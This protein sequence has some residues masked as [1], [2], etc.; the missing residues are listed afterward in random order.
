M[1]ELVDKQKRSVAIT[2]AG[3]GLGRATALAFARKGYRVFGT[4]LKP[5]E[6]EEL[7]AASEGAVRLTVCDI[8]DEAAV[9]FWAKAV[10]NETGGG[11]DLLIQNAG[12]L[13]PGPFEVL[14]LNTVRHEF[15]VNLFG[16]LSV[17]NAFI[18]ALRKQRGRIIYI[19]TFTASLPLPF[20][21]PSGAS[22]AALE[23]V[24][25]VQRAELKP[26]GIDVVIAAP[27]NMRTGGPALT[28]AALK[29]VADGFTEGQREL[30]GK[31]FGAFADKLNAMQ[32]SG[33]AATEAAAR[34]VEISELIPAPLR[35]AVGED[36]EEILRFVREA[37]LADQDLRRLEI[38]GLGPDGRPGT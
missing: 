14:K 8:T 30:Y 27:G 11:L 6:V 22:K 12:I 24:A 31:S 36:A 26:F 19:S 28:A 20:N 33:M 3:G 35:V 32:S 2:G 5:E 7:R 18:P 13:S 25:T 17:A 21:G 1:T 37:S 38:M 9:F 10:I 23:V 15:E 34:V 16:A 29:R 4:A